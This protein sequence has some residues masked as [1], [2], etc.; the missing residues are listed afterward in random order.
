MNDF[1]FQDN[2]T[3]SSKLIEIEDKYRLF[4]FTYR[5]IKVYEMVRLGIY[6]RLAEDLKIFNPQP[7]AKILSM[8]L[9]RRN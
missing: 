3:L 4:D 5:N 7:K 2:E 1:I 9:W 8:L 6:Y